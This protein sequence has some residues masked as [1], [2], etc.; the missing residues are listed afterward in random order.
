MKVDSSGAGVPAKS[1]ELLVAG[2][3]EPHIFKTPLAK[4]HD[5]MRITPGKTHAFKLEDVKVCRQVEG[6]LD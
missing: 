1:V 3:D 6:L 4:G 2:D 5:K